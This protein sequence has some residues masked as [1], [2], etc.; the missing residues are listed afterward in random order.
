MIC[1]AALASAASRSRFL[2]HF[3]AMSTCLSVVMKSLFSRSSSLTF[4]PSQTFRLTDHP[5]SGR[6]WRHSCPEAT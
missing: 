3:I 4:F 5:P 1:S 2:L 6:S